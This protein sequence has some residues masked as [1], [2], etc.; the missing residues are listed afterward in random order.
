MTKEDIGNLL[1]GVRKAI[2]AIDA[3]Y[4]PLRDLVADIEHE[5]GTIGEALDLANDGY[6]ELEDL[7]K[8]ADFLSTALGL[9][10]KHSALD[11]LDALED[12]LTEQAEDE[13][14]DEEEE[15]QED[16]E[17]EEAADA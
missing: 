14:E 1:V 9:I 16:E 8:A 10:E 7:V 17:D 5:V 11:E 13:E 6:P 12:D 2:E 4:E 15:D 3:E